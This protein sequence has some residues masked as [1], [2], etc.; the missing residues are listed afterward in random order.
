M[1][2]FYHFILVLHAYCP[3]IESFCAAVTDLRAFLKVLLLKARVRVV[4]V[5]N[6]FLGGILLSVTD[7][8]VNYAFVNLSFL[9]VIH[10]DAERQERLIL[11]A[12]LDE[13]ALRLFYRHF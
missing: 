1:T 13:Y 10:V 9:R 5:R 2:G 8:F 11:S 6:I 4:R 7:A 3:K 12:Y